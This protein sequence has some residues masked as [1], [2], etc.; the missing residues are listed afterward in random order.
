M[1]FQKREH[2]NKS[3]VIVISNMFK[4]KFYKTFKSKKKV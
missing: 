1:C 4:Q 2:F 3:K